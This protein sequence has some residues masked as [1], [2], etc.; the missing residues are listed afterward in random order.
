MVIT[1]DTLKRHKAPANGGKVEMAGRL[2]SRHPHAGRSPVSAGA[3]DDHLPAG[4]ITRAG[5]LAANGSRSNNSPKE[6]SLYPGPLP[7]SSVSSP[8]PQGP[9]APSCQI[10]ALDLG[11]SGIG[12]TPSFLLVYAS[13]QYLVLTREPSRCY[14]QIHRHRPSCSWAGA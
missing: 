4:P 8:P 9:R 6:K 2:A 3:S 11:R 5:H 14:C 10:S 13:K 1:S 12:Q 7:S